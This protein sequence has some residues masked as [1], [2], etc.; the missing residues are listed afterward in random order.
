[1][2]KGNEVLVIKP[3]KEIVAI[4]HCILNQNA[5]IN[6][7]ERAKG[8]FPVAQYL[9]NKGVAF[10]QL[11]CPEF[12]FLGINRPPMTYEDYHAIDGYREKCRD[13][14]LPIIQQLKMYVANDYRY[15]GIIGINES[16]NCSITGQ[17]GVLM[18]EFF[19]L[20]RIETLTTN[21]MEIPTWY[22]EENEGNIMT[23][24]ES[25]IKKEES[26]NDS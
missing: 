26:N 1:M 19:S 2:R 20:C 15:I 24:V 12:L 21:Y 7:W 13:L 23:L 18:E 11:P 3:Q 10:I 9:L 6:D 14:L 16:P 5:V 8:A 4:S 22:S 25:F 17:R